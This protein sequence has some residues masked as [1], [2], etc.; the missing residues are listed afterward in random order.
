MSFGSVSHWCVQSD[1]SGFLFGLARA[2]CPNLEVL[3]EYK[4]TRQTTDRT[5]TLQVANKLQPS[6][7]LSPRDTHLFD[8]QSHQ[9]Y[10]EVNKADNKW[11]SCLSDKAYWHIMYT[12]PYYKVLGSVAAKVSGKPCGIGEIIAACLTF[13]CD[14]GVFRFALRLL[15]PP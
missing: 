1:S 8:L 5:Q 14:S 12:T 10:E 4:D 2:L 6:R 9:F 11:T 7:Q 13:L 3:K 15:P